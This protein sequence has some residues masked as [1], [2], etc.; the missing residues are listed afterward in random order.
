MCTVEHPYDKIPLISTVL[1]F[2]FFALFLPMSHMW[3]I[4][5][6]ARLKN[7]APAIEVVQFYKQED[8]G[9]LKR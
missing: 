5:F 6:T 3:E 4:I 9:V 8:E 2:S 7:K 1:Y